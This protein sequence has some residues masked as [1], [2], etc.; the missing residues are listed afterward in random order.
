MSFLQIT[1]AILG[2]FLTVDGLFM[3]FNFRYSYQIYLKER[4]TYSTKTPPSE[5]KDIQFQLVEEIGLFRS[6]LKSYGWY[7]WFIAGLFMNLWMFHVGLFLLNLLQELFLGGEIQIKK[8]A[9]LLKIILF[10]SVY[11]TTISLILTHQ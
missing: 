2:V 10:L 6:F 5:K 3:L 7:Y 8:S 9:F 11:L 1:Y 4:E